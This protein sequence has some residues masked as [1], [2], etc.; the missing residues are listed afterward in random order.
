MDKR[1]RNLL[2]LIIAAVIFVIAAPTIFTYNRLASAENDVDASWSQVENVMQRR[3]DLVPN[4]VE[5]VQGSMQQEQEIFGNIAEARQAYNEANTPEETV[6]ANDE[7]SGQLS[8][9]VNVIREDYPEL[10]SNNNVRTLMSQL[11]GTENRIS[12]ERRRYIQ[13]V[14]QYNQLLVRFPNNLVAN[15]FNFDRK[16][17]FEAEE[18]AQEVPE[19][20]FDIDTSE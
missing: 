13:S 18:G 10:S 20:D 1:N 8:T 3:A 12:T 2:L 11:E 6:E 4:L 15:I 19:V 5:S 14:N 7:L 9:M 16:D 17:N